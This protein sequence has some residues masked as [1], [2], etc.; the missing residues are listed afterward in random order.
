MRIV[1]SIRGIAVLCDL[2]HVESEFSPDVC[3][4]IVGIGGSFPVLLR[5][6]G[7]FHGHDA[8]DNRM[9]A[10]VRRVVGECAQGKSVFV[11]VRGLLNHN[12]DEVSTTH[13]VHQVA[14]IL[15]AERI[16]AH[17]LNQ[18]SAIGIGMRLP[19]IFLGSFGEALFQKRLDLIL[20]E[21]VDDF[22]VREN[23]VSKTE[24]GRRQK[25]K[26]QQRGSQWSR[27]PHLA[28]ELG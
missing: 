24:M 10:V 16:V 3:L 17:V 9:P 18:R 14:E 27:C 26:Q 22:F 8:I 1:V 5:Q 2:H 21:E 12:Y 7:E 6:L 11:E 15:V 4:G 28:G 25:Q 19:Q 20:P 23:R 13:V